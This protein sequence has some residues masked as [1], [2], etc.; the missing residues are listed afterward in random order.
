MGGSVMRVALFAVLLGL[1]SPVEA[2]V[3]CAEGGVGFGATVTQ[4]GSTTQWVCGR[5]ANG[6][7]TCVHLASCKAQS[8]SGKYARFGVAGTHLCG[9][10]DDGRLSCARLR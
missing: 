2:R 9:I 4:V 5:L 1:A 7:V 10:N 3:R 6:R 8:L